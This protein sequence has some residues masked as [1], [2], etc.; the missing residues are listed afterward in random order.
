VLTEND[1]RKLKY[2]R[3]L[4]VPFLNQEELAKIIKPSVLPINKALLLRRK[5]TIA[6]EIQLYPD[7][8]LRSYSVDKRMMKAM[9]SNH[10]LLSRRGSS[11]SR[12]GTLLGS[13]IYKNTIVE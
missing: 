6:E 7:N 9:K 11:N 4:S 3:S 12:Q 5:S 13:N 1:I 8:V 2:A 10:N